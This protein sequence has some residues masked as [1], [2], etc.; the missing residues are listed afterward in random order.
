M[1]ILFLT[2]W[3]PDEV[4]PNHGIFIRDQVEALHAAGHQIVVICAKPN[5]QKFGFLNA[6]VVQEFENGVRV[7]R[8]RIPRSLPLY[9]QV[10]FFILCLKE[11]LRVVREFRPEILHG[12]IGYPG[13]VWTALLKLVTGVPAVLTEHT[14]LQN[15]FRTF[16]HRWLTIWAVNKMNTLI[17]VSNHSASIIRRY[18]GKG[19][20]VIPNIV[21]FSLFKRID[22]FPP[23][24]PVSIGFLGGS[25]FRKKGLDTIILALKDQS[26]DFLLHIGGHDPVE[27]HFFRTLADENG[28]LSHC[29]FHGAIPRNEVPNF[30]RRIHFFVS[31]SIFESFGVSIAEA[32]AVGLPVICTDSGGPSDFTGPWSGR[33]V[34]VGDASALSDAI[35]KMSF[36]FT[37]F[38]RDRIRASVIN[39]FQSQQIA[40]HIELVYRRVIE[41]GPA[42]VN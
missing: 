8:I 11:S 16:V 14:L 1:R 19:S 4:Q 2:P 21:D 23:I 40:K 25:F 20:E 13:A 37:S 7:I 31:A 36:E 42:G 33:T 41:T 32:M 29:I 24:P 22:S 27:E 17:T 15:N 28:I 9:N 10:N 38:D 35:K 34:P 26:F 39:R 6:N 3:Y 12:N 18:T 5:R 30:L